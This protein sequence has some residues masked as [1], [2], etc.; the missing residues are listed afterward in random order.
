MPI[1][2]RPGTAADIPAAASIFL[3]AFGPQ[4][5]MDLLHPYRSQYPQDM[6]LW[7]NRFFHARYW[8]DE[9]QIFLVAVDDTDNVVK[10]FAWFR[11]P[12]ADPNRR[13]AREG[14]YTARGWVKPIV[15]LRRK[16]GEY[17]WPARCAD[18]AAADIFAEMH[19]SVE[20]RLD[21]EDPTPPRRRR[22]WYLSTLGVDPKTQ[23]QGIGSLLIRSAM[24]DV[25]DVEGSA[26]W[27]VGLKDVE[28]FY[29]RLGFTQIGRANQGRLADWDGGSI[30]M[31]E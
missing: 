22:A 18:P 20:E 17:L 2:V 9:E 23:G 19:D 30:M 8:G 25:I 31:R 26:C 16:T 5:M 27:L 1:T 3:A 28:P 29:E 10:G 15:N 4:Q 6:S 14:W 21:K 7:A 24:R 11:R 13:A 12:Y